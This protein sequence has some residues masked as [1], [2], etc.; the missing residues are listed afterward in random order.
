MYPGWHTSCERGCLAHQRSSY[1]TP[2]TSHL[3]PHTPHAA[4]HLQ[5]KFAS[6]KNTPF[7]PSPQPPTPTPLG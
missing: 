4:A 5:L 1:D 7:A 6:T 3:T 2:H